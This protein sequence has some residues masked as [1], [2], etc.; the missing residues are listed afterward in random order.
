MEYVIKMLDLH[1]QPTLTMRAIYPVEKLPEFFG[2][3]YSGVMAYLQE[4]GETPVGMP[5]GIYYNLDMSALDV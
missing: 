5:F 2:I 1:D 3:A 4:L